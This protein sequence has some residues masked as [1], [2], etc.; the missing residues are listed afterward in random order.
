MPTAPQQPTDPHRTAPEDGAP[1]APLAPTHRTG[2]L[3]TAVVYNPVRVA[4]IDER[5]EVVERALAE[6]GWPAPVWWETTAEDPGAGQARQAVEAGAEVVFAC[7]GD[8]TVRSCIDG[9]AGGPAARAVLP[10]GTGNL[11]ATNLGL[12]QD[13]EAGVQ[14]VLDAGRR[15]IDVGEVDGTAFAVMAGMGFDADCSATPRRR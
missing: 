6:A 11:L 14:V 10:A 8:G 3:R 4:D 5:R 7:G 9:L 1:D 15:R 2:P 12:P 13:A